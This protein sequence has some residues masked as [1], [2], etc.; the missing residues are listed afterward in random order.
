MSTLSLGDEQLRHILRQIRDQ[1]DGPIE[2][3]YI[4][5]VDELN[6]ELF[7]SRFGSLATLSTDTSK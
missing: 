1:V 7:I 4:E 2:P 5:Q 3:S 6:F